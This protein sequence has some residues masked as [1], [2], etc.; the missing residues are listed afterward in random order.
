MVGKWWERCGEYGR[1]GTY[2]DKVEDGR[3]YGCSVLLVGVSLYSGVGMV[4]RAERAL[5]GGD[6]GRLRAYIEDDDGVLGPLAADL[7]I[8]R[9]GDVVEEETEQG[10]AFF[11]FEADDVRCVC[12][13]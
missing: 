5:F 10:V 9:M 8:L 4:L 3:V 1:E 2:V 7:T 13:Q 11:L 6:R 12:Q